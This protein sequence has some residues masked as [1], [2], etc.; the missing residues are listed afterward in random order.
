MIEPVYIELM[1]LELDGKASEA[2]RAELR[3]YLAAHPAASVHFD[4]L[5]RLLHRLDAHPQAQPPAELH[6]RIMAAVDRTV[7]A[8]AAGGF[9]AWLGSVL[10]AR[11]RRTLATFATGLA[12][13]VFLLAAVQF[14]GGWEAARGVDPGA[15]SGT[16]APPAAREGAIVLDPA[17]DGLSGSFELWIEQ[18]VT[19]ISA[20]L[21]TAQAVDWTLGFD[22]G[23]AVSRIEA[24]RDAAV[25]FGARGGEV[26]AR[27]SGAG[28]YKIVLS[29][30]AEPV[31]SVVLQVVRDGE[32]VVERAASPMR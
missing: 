1:N 25:V 21:E 2:Q 19:V 16:I 29:G 32:V 6:P 14:G 31:Q 22:P 9:S 30:R 24:P 5:G 28:A 12:T 11:R 18:G 15:V 17:A 7:R 8:P 20:H 23:L 26:H 3:R 13:G 10:G 27:H 4:E